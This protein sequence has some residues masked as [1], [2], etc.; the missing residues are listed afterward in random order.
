MGKRKIKFGTIIHGVGG[1]ISG[2][3]HPDV[4]VDQSV[5]LDFYK[6]QALKA[7]DGKFDLV[8]IADGLYINEQSIPHFLNRFEPITI[9]SALA[10]VTSHIGLVGTVSTSYSEPFNIAR[11]FASLDQISQ[12]RAGWNV[13][14]TPLEKTA[15]NFNKK[16]DEHPDH[17]TRYRIAEEY[18]DVAQGLWDSWDD[19]AFV[20][21][22]EN[23]LFFDSKKLHHLNHEGEF[24]SVAG[25][26][27]IQ[28]SNQGQPVIFQAGS[29][30]AGKRLAGKAADAVFTAHPTLESAQAYYRDVK[31]QATKLGRNPDDIII[32]P[33]LSPIIGDTLE[34]AEQKYEQLANL[35]SID[36]ALAYLGRYFDHHDFTQ[37]ALDEPFPELGDIG[38]NSFRST[39]DRIKVEAKERKLTLRQV[40][41]R[42]ATPRTEFIGTPDVIADLIQQWFEERG[43][44]GF[45]IAQ[46]LPETLTDFVDKVVPILQKRGVYR[47]DYNANTLRG[48]LGLPF[49]ESR[50]IKQNV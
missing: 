21:D 38:K 43:A 39:T 33:A 27:N 28:R 22:K 6:E 31:E 15:L 9:L 24:F 34:E 46:S 19:D 14:T 4:K 35:V 41:I 37:Y 17:A 23:D 7:E 2:W 44:D 48:H 36:R 42:E 20:G 12:G 11:Q 40:A 3:R 5:S 45:M 47:T 1:N 18:I 49:K 10:S 25:P 32:L 13:V 30:K 29:S 50:Y 26:L 16:V 8:F